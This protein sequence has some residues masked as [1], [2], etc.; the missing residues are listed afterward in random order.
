MSLILRLRLAYLGL[1]KATVDASR[2]AYE[3]V[4]A[5]LVGGELQEAM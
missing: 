5:N 2:R 1:I 3:G 4:R